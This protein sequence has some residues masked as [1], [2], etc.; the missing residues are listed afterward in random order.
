MS[1]PFMAAPNILLMG[2]AGTGKTHSIATLV[3]SGIEVF[4]VGL[5]NGLESLLGFWA[6]KGKPVPDNLHW[7]IIDAPKASF[8]E[9]ASIASNVNTMSLESL[10]KLSDKNRTK[11]DQMI[12][13]YQN[14][15]NFKDQRTGKEF[16]AVETWGPER[17]IVIDGLTGLNAA[18]MANVIGGKP[19]RSMPDWQL[20]QDTVEKCLRKL[21]DDCKCWFVLIAHVEREQDMVLGGIKLMP[22]TLGKALAPKLSPMFSDVILTVREGT[23]WTWDCASSMADVKARNL[24]WASG[25]TPDFGPIV[26]KWKARVAAIAPTS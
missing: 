26:K 17:A 23:K 13:I 12:R 9:L 8:E 22:S 24:P 25:I 1:A 21:C 4:Y 16:G 5:E 19:V 20:A 11:Y 10:A 15:N 2:P 3:E 18:A 7:N 6:D 14:F